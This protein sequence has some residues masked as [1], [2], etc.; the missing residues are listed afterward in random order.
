MVAIVNLETAWPKSSAK[1]ESVEGVPPEPVGPKKKAAVVKGKAISPGQAQA[2][3]EC[4]WNQ[5]YS[6]LHHAF[7]SGKIQQPRTI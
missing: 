3:T 6:D 1:T 2:T 7:M 4:E 5:P